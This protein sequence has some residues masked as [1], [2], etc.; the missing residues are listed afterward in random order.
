MTNHDTTINSVPGLL[1]PV[2]Q[3]DLHMPQSDLVSN[4][5]VQKLQT[6]QKP[7]KPENKAKT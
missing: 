1:V 5:N 2:F 3:R 4:K 6:L 7:I